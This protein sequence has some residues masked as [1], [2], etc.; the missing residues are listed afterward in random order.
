MTLTMCGELIL[1][2]N[3]NS[4]AFALLEFLFLGFTLQGKM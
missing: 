2:P 4:A 1:E 3:V